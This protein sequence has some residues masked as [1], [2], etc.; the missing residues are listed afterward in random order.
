MSETQTLS[1]PKAL[2]AFGT[3]QFKTEFCTEICAVGV[4]ALPLQ[5]AVSTSS[6]ALADKLE[7]MILHSSETAQH[8]IIK[9]GVFFTGVIAGCSCADDPTPVDEQ[10]E[11]C[12]LLFRIDKATSAATVQL[13]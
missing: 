9:A 13:V 6:V 7:V 1:L 2:A 11:Y 4:S 8:V 5:Q 3:P 12:E 10:A